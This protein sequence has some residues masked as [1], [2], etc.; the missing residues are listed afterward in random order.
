M[1]SVRLR[2]V[3][4]LLKIQEG[5]EHLYWLAILYLE[6]PLPDHFRVKYKHEY[7]I[8]VYQNTEQGIELNVSPIY[9]YIL[10]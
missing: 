1:S 9:F 8:L 4:S 7:G 10:R 6:A 2:G 3:L 5:E